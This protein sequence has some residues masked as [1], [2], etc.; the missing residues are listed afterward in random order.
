MARPHL[1][2]YSTGGGGFQTDRTSVMLTTSSLSRVKQKT[3]HAGPKQTPRWNTFKTLTI[4]SYRQIL[5]HS[6]TGTELLKSDVWVGFYHQTNVKIAGSYNSSSKFST[7]VDLLG[8][9]R[10]ALVLL[11]YPHQE[12]S[13]PSQGWGLLLHS[14]KNRKQRGNVTISYCPPQ[15]NP[16]DNIIFAFWET[17]TAASLH[18]CCF[19]DILLDLWIKLHVFPV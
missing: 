13:L 8:K 19:H 16:T 5:I 15:N 12:A 3:K 18:V 11:A 14:K 2:V 9:N 1:P 7:V 10:V 17:Q 6:F 4:K